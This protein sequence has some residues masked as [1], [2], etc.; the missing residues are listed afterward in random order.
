MS[1]LGNWAIPIQETIYLAEFLSIYDEP[2]K[3][4]TH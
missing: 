4:C 3:M 2:S 1:S